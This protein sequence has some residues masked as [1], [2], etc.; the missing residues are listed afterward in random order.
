MAGPPEERRQMRHCKFGSN[1]IIAQAGLADAVMG[2]SVANQD[3]V[4]TQRT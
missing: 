4:V 1:D 3:L 2:E